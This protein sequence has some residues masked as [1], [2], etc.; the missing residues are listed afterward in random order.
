MYA[1]L[2]LVFCFKLI[3]EDKDFGYARSRTQVHVT[4]QMIPRRGLKIAACNEMY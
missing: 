4:C 2:R 1:A 3:V